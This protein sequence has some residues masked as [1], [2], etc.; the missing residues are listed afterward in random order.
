[1]SEFDGAVIVLMPLNMPDIPGVPQYEPS[2]EHSLTDCQ[3]CGTSCWIG[4]TQLRMLTQNP[5][6]VRA[7]CIPCIAR[8]GLADAK[9]YALDP[10]ADK[11]PRRRA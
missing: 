6:Q 9:V 5:L 1:M 3:L 10:N 8:I 2:I 7:Y 11:K 4:P